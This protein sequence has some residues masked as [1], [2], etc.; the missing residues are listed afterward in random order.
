MQK[1]HSM[2]SGVF[3]RWLKEASMLSD[4]SKALTAINWRGA[5]VAGLVATTVLGVTG[6][7]EAKDWKRGHYYGPGYV[8]VPPGHMRYYAP[9]PVFYAAPPPVVVYPQP[10][11][12]VPAYPAYDYGAPLGSL[13]LGVTLPLR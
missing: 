3:S 2:A 8:F 10:V 11:A 7:A 1:Q 9:A 6:V 12:F 5:I 13:S 4:V